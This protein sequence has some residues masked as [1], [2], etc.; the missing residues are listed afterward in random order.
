MENNNIISNEP[1]KLS[2]EE[3]IQVARI[4]ETLKNKQAEANAPF[5]KPPV[6][7]AAVTETKTETP[8]IQVRPLTK[9]QYDAIKG[10]PPVPIPVDTMAKLKDVALENISNERA[11]REPFPDITADAFEPVI[12]DVTVYNL[13]TKEKETL[14]IRPPWPKCNPFCDHLL[15][16]LQHTQ[17]G[18]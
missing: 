6:V 12:P 5:I 15:C 16:Q 14:H 2:E 13:D 8:V 4:M 18:Q 11:A 1:A 7:P 10:S 3:A 9:E 17:R